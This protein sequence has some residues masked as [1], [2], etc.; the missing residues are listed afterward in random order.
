MNELASQSVDIS[1]SNSSVLTTEG[2]NNSYPLSIHV[3]GKGVKNCLGLGD[4]PRSGA[5]VLDY[6]RQLSYHQKSMSY[7]LKDNIIFNAFQKQLFSSSAN[8]NEACS[9]R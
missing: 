8:K 1:P 6:N 3:G 4:S 2:C 7:V 5:S 9:P